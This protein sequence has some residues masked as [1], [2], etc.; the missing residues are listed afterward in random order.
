M[1]ESQMK[2][3]EVEQKKLRNFRKSFEK[4]LIG[5]FLEKIMMDVYS[6]FQQRHLIRVLTRF[7]ESGLSQC[8]LS[9]AGCELLIV[10]PCLD[11]K[12]Q[13]IS[14]IKFLRKYQLISRLL[15]AVD[16]RIE[17]ICL[18]TENSKTCIAI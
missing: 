18:V 14:R 10:C 13:V 2:V 5:V 12:N 11:V 16:I 4:A 15:E 7:I 8:N 3:I 17:Q 6:N 9:V 1:L